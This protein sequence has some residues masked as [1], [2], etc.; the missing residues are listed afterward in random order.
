M[1]MAGILPPLPKIAKDGSVPALEFARADIAREIVRRRISAGLTQQE[2]AR[3]V[4]VRPETISRLEAAKHLPH[5]ET[6]ER[7]DRALPALKPPKKNRAG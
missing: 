3:R 2:L 1:E 6:I 4:G 7:I 5:A